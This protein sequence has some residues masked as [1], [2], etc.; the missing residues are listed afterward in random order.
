MVQAFHPKKDTSNDGYSNIILQISG[1]F[2]MGGNMTDE[3]REFFTQELSAENWAELYSKN[4][5]PNRH[6]GLVHRPEITA[7]VQDKPKLIKEWVGVGAQNPQI[8]LKVYLKHYE[9]FW[10]PLASPGVEC[11]TSECDI[12]H[13]LP[14]PVAQT[15]NVIFYKILRNWSVAF[16]LSFILLAVGIYRKDRLISILL[17]LPV[18]HFLQFLVALPD[19]DEYRYVYSAW[20]ILPVI[21]ALLI[22]RGKP[23]AER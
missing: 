5:T 21:T 14:A 10:N 4:Q 2:E 1:T 20:F 12:L 7:L 23:A 16:Y 19:T 13:K 8:Y 6:D 18:C 15:Y 9:P 11:P 17:L 22:K 3:Q